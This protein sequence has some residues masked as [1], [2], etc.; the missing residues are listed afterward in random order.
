MF[1]QLNLEGYKRLGCVKHNDFFSDDVHGESVSLLSAIAFA[2][3]MIKE[4]Y[5]RAHD[6]VQ[7]TRANK[8]R[9]A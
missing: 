4:T 8:R 2:K 6:L 1:L 3:M 7:W 9:L 5:L